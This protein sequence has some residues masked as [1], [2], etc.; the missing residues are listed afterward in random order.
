MLLGMNFLGFNRIIKVNSPTAKTTMAR[1]IA[2]FS[3][4]AMVLAMLSDERNK[5]SCATNR[6][7][8]NAK[9]K[10]RS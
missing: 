5:L 1:A 7:A 8:N 2:L 6:Q 4:D 9:G 10:T 3:R